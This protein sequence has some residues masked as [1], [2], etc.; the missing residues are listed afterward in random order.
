MSGDLGLRVQDWCNSPGV[1]TICVADR[2]GEPSKVKV[3]GDDQQGA[4]LSNCM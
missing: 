3:M 2:P 4:C 1:N